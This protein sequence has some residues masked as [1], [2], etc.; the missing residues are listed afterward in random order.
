MT[1]P[2]PEP[3]NPLPWTYNSVPDSLCHDDAVYLVRAANSFPALVEA[4]EGA[5]AC[6]EPEYYPLNIAGIKRAL[7]IARGEQP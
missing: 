4:L 6:L 1:N 7:A 2:Y 3:T 5:L